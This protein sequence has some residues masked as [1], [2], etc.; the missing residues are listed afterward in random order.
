MDIRVLEYPL[1]LRSYLGVWSNL[2]SMTRRFFLKL[3]PGIAL[4]GTPTIAG[5][6]TNTTKPTVKYLTKYNGYNIHMYANSY[7]NPTKLLGGRWLASKDSQDNNRPSYLFSDIRGTCGSYK[8]HTN[9]VSDAF[10]RRYLEYR[11]T[12]LEL[13]TSYQRLLSLIDRS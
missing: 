5:N 7:K 11:G 10:K 1:E 3:F 6:S 2:L 8:L 13:D 9:F 4:I 12:K